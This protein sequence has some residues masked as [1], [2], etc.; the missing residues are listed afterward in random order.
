LRAGERGAELARQILA[1]SQQELSE[2]R[3]VDVGHIAEDAVKFL[4]SSLPATIEIRRNLKVESGTVMGNSTQ[5]HQVFM[6]L[7]EN[8][9]HAMQEKGGVLGVNLSDATLSDDDVS[10]EFRLPPGD[11]LRI[12]VRD[13]GHGMDKG[14]MDRIFDPFYTTAESGKGSGMGLSAVHGIVKSHQGHIHVD[15]KPGEGT[16]FDILLPRYGRVETRPLEKM[17]PHA[18]EKARIL[19]VDDEP[20]IIDIN[21][22]MLEHLGHEVVAR[23]SSLEALECFRAQPNRFDLVITDMTMPHMTGVDLAGRILQIHPGLPIILC[24]GFS[25]IIDSEKARE[26][27]I[28]ELLLKPILARQMMDAIQRA[29]RQNKRQG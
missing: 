7:C 26:R 24:T 17:A 3:P 21:K 6:N 22:N 23:T 20:A 27:G 15:S 4:K 19:F 29:L 10:P 16:C 28:R 11:Y 12:S 14:V 9:A 13:T 1:F 25:E 8:A 2:K 18:V 5:I